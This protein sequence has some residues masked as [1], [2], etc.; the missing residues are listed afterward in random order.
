[1][2][3]NGDKNNTN[4]DDEFTEK[5]VFYLILDVFFLSIN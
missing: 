1:M 4:I 5:M 2:Y 3:F